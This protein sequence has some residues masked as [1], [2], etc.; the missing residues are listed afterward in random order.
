MPAGIEAVVEDGFATLDFV[1]RSLVGPALEALRLAGSKVTKV[2]VSR[3]PMV[4]NSRSLMESKLIR[5][6][7]SSNSCCLWVLP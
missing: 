3:I 4:R 6:A 7:F 1:D 2:F 5:R